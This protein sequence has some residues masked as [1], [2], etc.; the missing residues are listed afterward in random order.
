MSLMPAKRL[1]VIAERCVGCR[2]CELS[3][4]MFHYGGA[5]NPRNAF[6]RVESNREVGLNKPIENIDHPHVCRQC[7]PTPCADACPVDAFDSNDALS[8]RIVDKDKCTGCEQ[9]FHECPYQMIVLHKENEEV[10]AGKCDLCG[11]VPLCVS[12]C[13]VG[14]LIFE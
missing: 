3:C 9:C 12:Y 8:I 14:A 7:N 13:P 10:K 1:K 6:I 2:I 4:S 11:G 5:F